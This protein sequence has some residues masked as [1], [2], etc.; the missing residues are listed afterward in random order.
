MSLG[1]HFAISVEQRARLQ[2]MPDDL[3]RVDFVKEEIEEPWETRFLQETDKAWEAIHRCLGE[4]PPEIEWFYPV[5]PEEGRYA[6]P[7]QYGTSPLKLCVLGGRRLMQDESRYFIRLIEAEEV[8]ALVPALAAID[9]EELRRRYDRYCSLL[10]EYGDEDFAYTWSYFSALR[11]FFE[12][13]AVAGRA[14][15]FTADQ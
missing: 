15:I 1:V 4:F 3:R 7:E 5:P 9:A 14:V 6:L 8:A 10:P 2:S 11:T 12:R 13:A